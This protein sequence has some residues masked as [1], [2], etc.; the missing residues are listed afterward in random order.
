MSFLLTALTIGLVGSFHCVGMCGPIALA[1]PFD[2]NSHWKALGSILLYNTGRIITYALMGLV[3]GLLGQGLFLAGMQSYFAIGM[4]VF[5]LLAAIF[6]INV[7]GNLLRLPWVSRMY[8]W[9]KHSLGKLLKG[10]ANGLFFIGLLNGLLPCGLVYMAIVG[11]LATT[12][13]V[14]GA[15]YMIVFGLG[16][17]P[18]MAVAAFSARLINVNLRTRIRKLYPV[19]LVVIALLFLFRGISFHMPADM[20][21]WEDMNNIPMCH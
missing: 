3:I 20:R 4:G 17:I 12:S 16:T 8:L 6:S 14:Q 5:L 2:R 7:E 21:F 1:L 15:L 13:V 10:N 9:L 19:F 18:L 11:A